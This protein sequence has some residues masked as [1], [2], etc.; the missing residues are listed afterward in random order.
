MISV[1]ALWVLAFF[2]FRDYVTDYFRQRL[3]TI[4]DELFD[5]AADGGIAF[6]HRGYTLARTTLNGF[7]R[8][9][10]R[11]SL[12]SL[13]AFRVLRDQPNPQTFAVEYQAAVEDLRPEQRAFL[14][15]VLKRMHE[16]VA[17]HLVLASP[18]LLFTLVGP[19]VLVLV[20]HRAGGRVSQT[21]RRWTNLSEG[22]TGIDSLAFSYGRMP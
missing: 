15:G 2:F 19:L 4:R 8:F 12:V 21:V 1:T 6:D 11:V 20:L 7:I 18:V 10:D 17:L 9:G 16:A 3:F 22:T 5:W 13:G 14:D